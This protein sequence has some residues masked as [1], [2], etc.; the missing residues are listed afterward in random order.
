MNSRL[1]AFGGVIATISAMSLL[2][3]PP[4]SGQAPAPAK[5]ETTSGTKTGS[6]PRAAEGHPD[7]GGFWNNASLTPF[8]RPAEFGQKQFFTE[9]EAAAFERAKLQDVN[10]DRRD[11]GAQEDLGRA[12]NEAWFDR[13]SRVSKTFRTSLISDPPDG[14]VP[15]MTPEAQKKW[16][17]IQAEL[18]V[19]GADGPEVRP[20]PDRCLMFSQVGPPMLPG[21][22]DDNYNIVQTRDYVAIRTEMG[23]ITRVIPLDGSPHLPSYMRQWIGDSRGHWEGNTLVVD[24]TNFRFTDRSRFG[25]VYEDGMTDENLHVIERFTRTDPDTI[26]YQAT[27]ADPTVYTKPWTVDVAMNKIQGPIFEYAC[28]EGNYG[29]EG[30]L[31]GARAEEKKA[32]SPGPARR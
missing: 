13:G 8:Q 4:V 25:V 31:A 5:A 6:V 32:G 24:T 14:R 11:G 27:V 29:L 10:R 12:Y 21:N 19:H 18:A 30:I 9:Q 15:P 26:R 28:H 2:T 3:A 23:G 20:L 16:Q 1:S 7:L 17:K 22:Y